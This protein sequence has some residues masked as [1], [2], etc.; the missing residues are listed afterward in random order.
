MYK[1]WLVVAIILVLLSCRDT[2]KE[3][4]VVEEL[5]ETEEAVILDR[6]LEAVSEEVNKEVKDLEEAIKALDSI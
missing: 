4:T 6:E 1:N 5:P 3:E 2:K